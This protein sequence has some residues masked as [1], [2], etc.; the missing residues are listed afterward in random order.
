M[1]KKTMFP[2]DPKKIR[3]LL[4]KRNM[5]SL[6]ASREI[7][8]TD[9]YLYKNAKRIGKYNQVT[10]NALKQM[11]GINPEDYAPDTDPEEIESVESGFDYDRLETTIYNALKKALEEYIHG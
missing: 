2:A 4:K 7:G 9:D 8:Y 11:Y 10:V 1:K 5:T 3:I 6:Q